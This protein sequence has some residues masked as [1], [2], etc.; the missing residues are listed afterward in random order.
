MEYAIKEIQ[1]T[2]YPLLADF[3]YEAIFVPEGVEPP[4]RSIINAPELQVYITDFGKEKD[5]ICFVAEA[6]NKVVGA[7][8]C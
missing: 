5:D 4:E 1:P 7:F 8:L 3:L 6:D 2:E